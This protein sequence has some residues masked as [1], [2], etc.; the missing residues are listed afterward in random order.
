MTK[1][2][3]LEL[4]SLI[5]NYNANTERIINRYLLLVE[6][7]STSVTKLFFQAPMLLLY[8]FKITPHELIDDDCKEI[9]AKHEMILEEWSINFERMVNGE[10]VEWIHKLLFRLNRSHFPDYSTKIRIIGY[11]KKNFQKI[12]VLPQS[13]LYESIP[14]LIIGMAA[15]LTIEDKLHNGILEQ[16]KQ[17]ISPFIDSIEKLIA[18]IKEEL[19]IADL[20]KMIR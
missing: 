19:T 3:L 9:L 15:I 2:K 13:N 5:Q 14:E 8:K 11:R 1:S 17:N 12:E 7:I 20:V 10:K 16:V 6:K 4:E 18:P